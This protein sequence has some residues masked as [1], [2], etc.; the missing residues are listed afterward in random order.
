LIRTADEV[1]LEHRAVL[2]EVPV[3]VLRAEP[4]HV[5]DARA[6]VP[7][8]VEDH[9]LACRRKVL[10]IALDVQ[11][12]PLAVG[13]HGKRDHAEHA[14]AHPFG[15]RLDHAPLT[16]RI[17]SLQDDDHARADV[18]HVILEGAELPLALPSTSV[19]FRA[20]VSF[21]W[22]SSS[23]P[24]APMLCTGAGHGLTPFSAYG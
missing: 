22:T 11:L 21:P 10:D 18:D 4:H 14:R 17:P 23:L 20:V 16:R 3:L 13:R 1:V 6:V 24:F 19:G 5:L 15:Q 8:T 12:R 9:D 2:Q 7:G